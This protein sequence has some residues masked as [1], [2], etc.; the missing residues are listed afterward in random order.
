MAAAVR[1]ELF[2][3]GARGGSSRRQREAEGGRQTHLTRRWLGSQTGEERRIRAK[4]AT[5]KQ[6]KLEHKQQQ[7]NRKT[8]N[9]CCSKR[10]DRQDE[11][12]G[13]RGKRMLALLCLGRPRPLAMQVPLLAGMGGRGG[14]GK[15]GMGDSKSRSQWCLLLL[16]SSV[17][18]L[19]LLILF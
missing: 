9:G 12:R 17:L 5:N 15:A 4:N 3:G 2:G 11:R 13:D 7:E 10:E 19:L 14:G 18:L 8:W 1:R 6:S 16:F